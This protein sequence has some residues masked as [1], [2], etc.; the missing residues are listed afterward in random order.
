MNVSK[1]FLN[2][3]LFIRRKVFQTGSNIVPNDSK[4]FYFYQKRIFNFF[5]III[6][7]FFSLFI[8]Y[9]LIMKNKRL[10]GLTITKNL[11][12]TDNYLSKF[13]CGKGCSK[14]I[15]VLELKDENELYYLKLNDIPPKSLSHLNNTKLKIQLY[16]GEL[17]SKKSFNCVKKYTF[18]NN[19][20]V[21]LGNKECLSRIKY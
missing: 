12:I 9:H 17:F 16:N 11:T 18:E 14:N 4:K 8:S 20:S 15:L 2:F 13:S 19:Y 6:L 7:I 10:D 1:L 5:M 3:L 21:E